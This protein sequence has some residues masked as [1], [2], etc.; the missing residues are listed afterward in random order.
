VVEFLLTR[1]DKATLLRF[2]RSSK[3][4]GWDEAL[5]MHYQ[6]AGVGELESQWKTWAAQQAGAA[7]RVAGVANIEKKIR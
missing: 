4:N 5:R 1:E 6:I 7:N 3:A 2:A